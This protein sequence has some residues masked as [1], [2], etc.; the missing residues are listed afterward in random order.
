VE[1]DIIFVGIVGIEDPLREGVEEAVKTCQRA[2]IIVRMVTGDNILTA[3]KIAGDCGILSDGGI[4]MEGPDFRKLGPKELDDILPRLQVLA[5]SSPTDKYI[6]VKRLRTNGEVVAVTG[7][8]TNDAP[9]LKEADVGLSMGICGTEVAKHASDI[10]ILDDNFTSIVK[11]VKWGRSVY[12]NIRKFLQFQL[13]VNIVALLTAF[14]G[15]IFNFGTP[16]NAVQLL[17]VNLIMDTLAALAFSTEKPTNALLNRRPHGR[18]G[19]LIS[20]VMWRN[21][22]SSSFYQFLIQLILLFLYDAR[23]NHLLIPGA[24]NGQNYGGRANIHYTIIFNTFVFMQIFNEFNSRKCDRSNNVFE[25]LHK[26]IIFVFIIFGTIGLQIIIVQ[27]TNIFTKCIPLNFNQWMLSVALGFLIL[28]FAA[29]V[30]LT[31]TPCI[32]KEFWEYPTD[33]ENS[34]ISRLLAK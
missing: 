26:N 31:V 24:D 20:F 16:L 14:F 4:A 5:R 30:R 11:S 23:G 1:D 3:K 17:W 27:F 18:D 9:A 8:G 7:D 25:G 34:I 2:G 12:D 22:I 6:L 21:I 10:V 33:A 29:V 32:P 19:K 15:A 28:P 13:T